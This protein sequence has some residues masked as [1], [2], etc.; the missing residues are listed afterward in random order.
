MNR[1]LD[2]QLV[3]EIKHRLGRADRVRLTARE[4]VPVGGLHTTDTALN[5]VRV[6]SDLSLD[7]VAERHAPDF[8][9]VCDPVYEHIESASDGIAHDDATIG[10]QDDLRVFDTIGGRVAGFQPSLASR[11]TVEEWCVDAFDVPTALG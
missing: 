3:E 2:T 7:G 4:K 10:A 8:G 5:E 11:S 6:R 1:V 9:L